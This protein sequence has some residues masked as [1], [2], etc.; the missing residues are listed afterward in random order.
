MLL[1]SSTTSA[2][3]II[4]EVAAAQRTDKGVVVCVAVVSSRSRS[5]CVDEMRNDSSSLIGDRTH[6]ISM[7]A[8]NLELFL[9]IVIVLVILFPLLLALQYLY[10]TLLFRNKVKSEKIEITVNCRM[11]NDVCHV[12]CH[13]M[14]SR[15]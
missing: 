3:G 8:R 14:G 4:D 1:A 10:C 12:S 9:Y 2:V 7:I 15:I 5:F 6:I 11:I 13:I